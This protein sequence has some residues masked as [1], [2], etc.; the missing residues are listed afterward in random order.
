MKL[1]FTTSSTIIFVEVK[2]ICQLKP[3][4]CHDVESTR[5][6]TGSGNEVVT[7]N[8]IRAFNPDASGCCTR[9]KV[10]K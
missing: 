5:T 10:L 8:G 3:E 1:L 7:A 2:A 9:L 6:I 4:R